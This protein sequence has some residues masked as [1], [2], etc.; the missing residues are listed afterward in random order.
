MRH[1]RILFSL[2]VTALMASASAAQNDAALLK[3]QS[4]EFSDASASGN[5]AVLD[6]T[7]DDRVT[8]INE[9]GIVSTKKDLVAGAGPQPKG[10][11]FNLTQTDWA[12]QLYG[13]VAVTSFTDVQSG[14]AH[15]QPLHAKF[16]STEVWLKEG[17]AWRMISS[18]TIALP[19]D[20]PSVVLPAKTL[21]EYAGTYR[22]GP[23]FAM[24]I[25]R[26]G[27]GLTASI[28]GDPPSVLKAEL[29]DVF[30]TPGQPRVRKIF[31]R[32]AS[33]TITGF[34]SRHEGQIWFS[35][36]WDEYEGR[37][38]RRSGGDNFFPSPLGGRGRFA[39]WFTA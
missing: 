26:G 19:D 6:R 18:Q 12:V 24:T 14:E 31:Q 35:N 20:P 22:G 27:D 28:G 1:K 25:A 11:H 39:L 7:L 2:A 4:Q 9:A 5:A 8:F 36:E 32:D 30:F 15:G 10:V 17:A 16:R 3:R 13:S 34:V 33:G 38:L 21:D 23:D 29:R 37:T